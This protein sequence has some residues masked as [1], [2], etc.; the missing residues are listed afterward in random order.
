MADSCC[1]ET[2]SPFPVIKYKPGRKLCMFDTVHSA[3]HFSGSPRPYHCQVGIHAGLLP[4]VLPHVFRDMVG[5]K[6][7][8]VLLHALVPVLSD[9]GCRRRAMGVDRRDDVVNAAARRDVLDL[10]RQL[11]RRNADRDPARMRSGRLTGG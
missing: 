9:Q 3:A 11:P 1:G 6:R 8:N 5:Q 2:L 4:V 10:P 7:D